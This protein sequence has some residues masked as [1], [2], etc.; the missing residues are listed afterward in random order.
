MNYAGLQPIHRATRELNDAGQELSTPT[1]Y[2]SVSGPT[3]GSVLA[4]QSAPQ[5]QADFYAQGGLGNTVTEF[6]AGIEQ[7]KRQKEYQRKYEE[8]LEMGERGADMLIEDAVRSFPGIE[9]ELPPKEM[10]Y[11]QATG[12]FMP[13]QFAKSVYEVTQAFR[14]A[15]DSA[16]KEAAEKAEQEA[17]EAAEQER[18]RGEYQTVG[19][20]FEG[21]QTPQAAISG[22]A[23][24][25][26]DPR[27]YKDLFRH[28]PTDQ[29]RA[30]RFKTI[31]E[32]QR[33]QRQ[34]V[35]EDPNKDPITI[36]RRNME[37]VLKNIS[38]LDSRIRQQQAQL[39][40]AEKEGLG[41]PG[42]QELAEQLRGDIASLQAEKEI[43]NQRLKTAKTRVASV[44]SQQETKLQQT[45]WDAQKQTTIR[46]AV[47]AVLKDA[48]GLL[49]QRLGAT[50]QQA[51]R[52][53][54]DRTPA[55]EAMKREVLSRFNLDPVLQSEVDAELDRVWGEQGSAGSSG[56]PGS[57]RLET[58][59]RALL[60]SQFGIENPSPEE[61]KLAIEDLSAQGVQ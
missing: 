38:S 32:G 5:T 23:G 6:A 10:F 48:A 27:A 17:K 56:T 47:D 18:L 3:A 29:D 55:G 31:A 28:I 19:G 52:L 16:E 33:A 12:A 59:A 9:R 42:V 46:D 40:Q 30:Q 43:E 60:K 36:E 41:R 21:A 61:L 45:E 53:L 51:T 57:S 7:K 15:Q 4:S 49:M 25:G 39:R 22:V 37:N 11:D 35:A 13:H 1:K 20:V 26:V 58:T 44:A 2:G 8:L 14:G 54:R 34:G 24:Q 50:E